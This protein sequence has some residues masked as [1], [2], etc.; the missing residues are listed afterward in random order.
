MKARISNLY[1]AETEWAKLCFTPLSG[2]L[3]VYAPDAEHNYARLKVGDGNTPLSDLP[4]FTEASID[5]K[6][7]NYQL[8]VD[9][10]AGF[11]S[12]YFKNKTKQNM[13]AFEISV[14]LYF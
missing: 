2:E 13:L 3:I 6:L 11:I 12:Q 9:A 8:N 7:R 10:D 5:T 14:D 4:F 1:K